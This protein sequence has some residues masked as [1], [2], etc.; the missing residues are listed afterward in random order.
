MTS[1]SK[2]LQFPYTLYVLSWL[3]P[4]VKAL[5]HRAQL[6]NKQAV[7]IS[8][9][10]VTVGAVIFAVNAKIFTIKNLCVSKFSVDNDRG[11]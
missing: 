2:Q 10:R 1:L 4:R 6:S 9:Y 7:N 5:S 11:S 3:C 8:Q